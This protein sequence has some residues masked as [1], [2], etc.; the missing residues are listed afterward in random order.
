MRR[1]RP[2]LLPEALRADTQAGDLQG[3]EVPRSARWGAVA[4]F[5]RPHQHL[6]C[7]LH[8]TDGETEAQ[9]V[10]VMGVTR[11]QSELEQVLALSLLLRQR[12][13]SWELHRLLT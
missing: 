13:H 6:L 3:C 8:L 10:G 11:T 12:L 4:G 9:R 5:N 7:P 1:G 2:G